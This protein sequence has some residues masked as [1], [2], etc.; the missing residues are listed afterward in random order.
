VISMDT[1]IWGRFSFDPEFSLFLLNNGV[2]RCNF[3]VISWGGANVY[4]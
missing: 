3:S 1:E 4:M 2:D